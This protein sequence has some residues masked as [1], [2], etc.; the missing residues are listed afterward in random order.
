MERP[1]SQRFLD[2]RGTSEYL[3][4][5]EDTIRAWVKSRSIPYS[6][7][8]RSVRFDLFKLEGWLKEKEVK[9]PSRFNQDIA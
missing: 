8:G 7:L 3:S 4:L 9:L 6:K 5:S 1:I 2:V